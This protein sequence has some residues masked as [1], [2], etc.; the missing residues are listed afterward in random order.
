[1]DGGFRAL[2]PGAAER[3]RRGRGGPE[4]LVILPA[5]GLHE[6]AR[7]R[8]RRRV[9]ERGADRSIRC[10][11]WPWSRPAGAA[12]RGGAGRARAGKGVYATRVLRAD[13][14]RPPQTLPLLVGVGLCRALAPHLPV[15]CRLKWPND[16]LVEVG[17][18]RRKLGG[19]LIEA[20]VRPGRG[21]R[22][23]HRLRRQPLATRRGDLPPRRRPRCVRGG[24][25]GAGSLADLTWDLVLGLEAELAHLGDDAAYAVESYRALSIHRP[26][27]R[28][29]CRVGD[30]GDRGDVPG[31]RRA[32]AGC[33]STAAARTDP[34][35][36]R[37]GDRGMKRDKSSK[38]E[39]RRGVLVL[40]DVGNTNTVFGIYRGDELVESFRLST[41]TERTADEYGRSCCRCSPCGGSIRRRPR[42]WS[43]SSRR[44]AAPSDPGAPGPALL[45]QASRC[46]SSRGCRPACRS[47]T[48][49]RPRW[50]RTASSTPSAARERYGAPVIVVDFGTATTFDVVNA[51]GE[52]MGGIITPG[53][54]H[55]GRGPLRPRLAPLPRST[56]A[57]PTEL[58]GQ[59][60]GRR[61]AGRHLLRLHRPGRRHPRAAAGRDPR[62]QEHHRHRRPGPL[63][64]SGSKYIREV[65]PD[66]TL[67]RP[68]ADLRA[69]QVAGARFC[70]LP[71]R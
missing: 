30:G 27:E 19:I 64:A 48:T 28:I 36:L 16:L 53:H 25:G 20:L 40:V 49:T 51:A 41:D 66:L 33:C 7:P 57:S 18:E 4:N 17:G 5:R 50:G 67:D 23:A 12:G 29:V 26:G 1:M 10:W 3:R 62:R 59:E 61:H 37:R 52:Y 46:S 47:A 70:G 58:V 42:R 14:A 8:H 54:R 35:G 31:V 32:S 24:L 15:P 2:R 13:D 45:R 44:A 6:R 60:H 65:D 71:L 63:I 38:N 22:G 39:R 21:D 9:P 56:S 11:C 43:I 68:E 34:R 55:L 69:Q